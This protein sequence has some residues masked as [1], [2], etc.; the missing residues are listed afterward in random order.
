MPKVVMPEEPSKEEA[1][2]LE[3]I[4]RMPV[5][6]ERVSRRFLKTDTIGLL[7]S[8]VDHL[9]AEGKCSFEGVEG[10][11]QAYQIMQSMPRKLFT[12]KDKTLEAVGF[13]PR[14]AML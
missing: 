11:H 9:Q 2:S 3:L 4:F 5:S 12:E 14:G 8:F 7:Y 10:Y 1:D 6:G 13:F